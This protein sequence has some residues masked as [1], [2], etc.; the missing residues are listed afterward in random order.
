MTVA[1]VI[2]GI[3]CG[4][5]ALVGVVIGCCVTRRAMNAGATVVGG[6]AMFYDEADDVLEQ[7]ETE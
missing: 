7:T 6:S 4:V 1:V 5:S 3:A 2:L